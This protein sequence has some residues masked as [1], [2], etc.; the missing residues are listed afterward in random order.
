MEFNFRK[1]IVFDFLPQETKKAFDFLANQKWL[2]KTD[3]YLAGGTAIALQAGYRKSIDLDFFTKNNKFD[4]TE[5]INNLSLCK[6]LKIDINKEGTLYARMFDAKISF[7]SYPFFI[8][9]MEFIKNGTIKILQLEDIAVMKIIAISQ[10]GKKRDFFD[11]YWCIKN[12]ESLEVII[13]KLPDQYPLIA[14]NYNHILKSLVYFEDAENDPELSV[15][16]NISWAEIKQF[17]KEE[18]TLISKKLI[19]D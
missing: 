15:S 3:W 1:K 8:P 11:L 5:L 10:R 7:I 19:L 18:I 2:E 13:K 9:K 6:E 17:F 4:N 16:I 14:H 12:T